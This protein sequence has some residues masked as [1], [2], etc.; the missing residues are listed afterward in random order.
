LRAG[1]QHHVIDIAHKKEVT[2]LRFDSLEEKQEWMTSLVG[3]MQK[4]QS[5]SARSHDELASSAVLDRVRAPSPPS[6]PA[7]F[8]ATSLSP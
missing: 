1:D 4:L 3:K 8:P 7:A 6:G 2:T 5:L